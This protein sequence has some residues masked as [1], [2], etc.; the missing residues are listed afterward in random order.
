MCIRTSMTNLLEWEQKKHKKKG[1][2]FGVSKYTRSSRGSE[3]LLVTNFT[4][5]RM[6]ARCASVGHQRRIGSQFEGKL[7]VPPAR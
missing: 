2:S 4:I 3:F 1:D 6:N 7:I 5:I